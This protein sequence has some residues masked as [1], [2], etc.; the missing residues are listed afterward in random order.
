MLLM[1]EA[2]VAEQRRALLHCDGI[3]VETQGVSVDVKGSSSARLTG[4]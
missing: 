1:A 3:R 4:V 2:P